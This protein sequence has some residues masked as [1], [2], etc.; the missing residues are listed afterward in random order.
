MT[1]SFSSSPSCLLLSSREEPTDSAV[2]LLSIS[3]LQKDKPTAGLPDK[4]DR[5]EES[6][7][8]Q[9]VWTEDEDGEGGQKEGKKDGKRKKLLE[10]CC[11]VRF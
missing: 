9:G 10:L 3:P 8:Q 6:V 5:E 4:E 1:S 7:G 2:S 11:I